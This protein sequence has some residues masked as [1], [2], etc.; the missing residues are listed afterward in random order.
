MGSERLKRSTE[1]THA[2]ILAAALADSAALGPCTQHCERVV[3]DL[4][5]LG[6][7][8]LFR[9]SLQG[10]DLRR[11]VDAGEQE[12]GVRHGSVG[13]GFDQQ[14]LDAVEGAFHTVF[15]R[16][17]ARPAHER[18]HR[19]VRRDERQV[20]LRVAAVDLFTEIGGDPDAIRVIEVNS[21]PSIRLLEQSGRGDLI[22]KIWHHTF[23]AMGLLGV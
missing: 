14:R 11:E 9:S 7:A 1:R 12:L 10:F 19:A 21:N 17:A 4:D 16:R 8:A 23:S 20:G 3:R 18:E 22:L 6:P 13:P 2:G 5:T 15:V